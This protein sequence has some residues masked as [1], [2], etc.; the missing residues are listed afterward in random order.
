MSLD[1]TVELTRSE[2]I[3]VARVR[4][5]PGCW[6]S[7][8]DS[9]DAGQ[10]WNRLEEAKSRWLKGA[11]RNR[12]WIPEPP[13]A[14]D[15]ELQELG[16]LFEEEQLDVNDARE[17]L[18]DSGIE[19]YPIP[20]L[21]EMWFRELSSTALHH[22]TS[23]LSAAPKATSPREIPNRALEGDVQPVALGKSGTVAWLRLDGALTEQ[24]YRE[25]E[26]LDQPLITERA[27]IST[28][29]IL[30]ATEMGQDELKRVLK[31]VHK[32]LNETN[33]RSSEPGKD[34]LNMMLTELL[35]GWYKNERVKGL[36]HAQVR[37]LKWS[38][39]LLR[40]RRLGFD[41]LPFDEQLALFEKHC[42][43]VDKLLD[44]SRKHADFVEH[45][46]EKGISTRTVERVRDQIRAVILADV[47]RLTHKEIAKKMNIFIPPNY[48]ITMEV[49]EVKKLVGEGRKLMK[50][51]LD[52]CCE[53][54]KPTVP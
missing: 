24:G 21:Q 41:R 7:V 42:A 28:L 2:K 35:K 20:L 53:D 14:E 38:L 40:Y 51:A 32:A 12:R 13:R 1:Y 16:Q 22:L 8:Q 54:L 34:N 33:N 15:T 10:L 3:L 18:Y 4:E 50:R 43:Y 39:A 47:E 30:E 49:P 17:M 25:I 45:G 29:T 31:Q 36:S 27:T 46:S 37:S 6:A 23:S 19:R 11:I 52:E 26:I 9:E 48:E 5:L 44:A